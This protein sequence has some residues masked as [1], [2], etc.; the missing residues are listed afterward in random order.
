MAIVGI[1]ISVPILIAAVYFGMWLA[2]QEDQER[3]EKLPL[4]TALVALSELL[5]LIWIVLCIPLY[6]GGVIGANLTTIIVYACWFL[7]YAYFFN[8]CKRF[9]RAS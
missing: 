1:V 3:K 6:Y 4:A 8:V 7:L 2:K 9:V 5:N